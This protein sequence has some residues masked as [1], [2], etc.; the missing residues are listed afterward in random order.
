[1]ENN[2]L[3]ENIVNNTRQQDNSFIYSAINQ[4][5]VNNSNSTNNNNQSTPNNF[6][7]MKQIKKIEPKRTERQSTKQVKQPIDYVKTD[8]LNA[9]TAEIMKTSPHN[10]G[11]IKPLM[12]VNINNS[13]KV[14]RD[15][16][17]NYEKTLFKQN[18]NNNAPKQAQ[19]LNNTGVSTALQSNNNTATV[20]RVYFILFRKE[21][22]IK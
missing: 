10:M 17:S 12:A 7:D 21:V 14:Y 5:S 2:K 8:N 16:V 22:I 3:K 4:G 6:I 19:H 9:K 18:I 20:N 15:E 1:M 11:N 13:N